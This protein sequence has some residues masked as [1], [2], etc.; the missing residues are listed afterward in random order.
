MSEATEP[1]AD[2][3]ARDLRDL[4]ERYETVASL[5]LATTRDAVPSKPGSR[6]PPG[7]QEILD[8]DE[9]SRALTAVDDWALF[10]AHVLVD[11]LD[12]AA[13]SPS[14]SARLRI[15]AGHAAHFVVDEDLPDS[16]DHGL[17]ALAMQDDLYEH[18]R[19]MRHL[20]GRAIRPIRT[21]HRCHAECGGQYVSPLGTS[22]NR[23]DDALTC[24]RCGHQVTYD[25]WS[26][27]PRARVKYITVEHAAK[28]AGTTPETIRKR[29]ARGK[30]GR[31]GTGRDVRYLV[32][33]VRS[34]VG[35]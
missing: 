34:G 24:D 3:I 14:T 30:W 20:A 26:R 9:L 32:D 8:D 19:T 17:M 29:A 23:H 6:V 18:L 2:K 22:D 5:D 16:D 12:V 7:M 25:V 11:E 21:G 1:S 15:A 35:A 33:D 4:A 10:L 28:M 31:T 27:W 13:V